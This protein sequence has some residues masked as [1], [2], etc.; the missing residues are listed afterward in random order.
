MNSIRAL[1]QR[2]RERLAQAASSHR[3]RRRAT[4]PWPPILMK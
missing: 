1:W 4:L 3:S 2:T